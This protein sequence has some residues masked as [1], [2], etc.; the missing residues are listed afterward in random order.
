MHRR[1]LAQIADESS[2]LLAAQPLT[3]L[4]THKP[5]RQHAHAAMA[6]PSKVPA[7]A[8]AVASL[9]KARKGKGSLWSSLLFKHPGVVGM[10]ILALAFCVVISVWRPLTPQQF[11][12]QWY[13]RAS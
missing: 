12:R 13:V 11:A 3:P 8:A 4:H 10:G 7:P 6:R 1:D 9:K 2:N 5:K